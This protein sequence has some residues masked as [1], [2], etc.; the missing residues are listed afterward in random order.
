MT[1]IP[2][3]RRQAVISPACRAS[4]SPGDCQRG[5]AGYVS[6]DPLGA[7]DERRCEHVCHDSVNPP[8][9]ARARALAR[10]GGGN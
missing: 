1:D 7:E 9:L 8:D 10:R 2:A 5:C 6:V 4:A 3:Q